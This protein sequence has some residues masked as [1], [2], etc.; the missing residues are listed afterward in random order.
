MFWA[1]E[2]RTLH[3]LFKGSVLKLVLNK[4]ECIVGL[5]AF[6]YL[7]I[8]MNM[9]NYDSYSLKYKQSNIYYKLIIYRVNLTSY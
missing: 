4:E 2:L 8:F 1:S 3:L 5:H 9:E 7:G 6:K